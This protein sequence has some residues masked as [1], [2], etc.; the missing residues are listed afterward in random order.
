MK[1]NKVKNYMPNN[2]LKKM[3]GLSNWL[4]LCSDWDSFLR[5]LDSCGSHCLHGA[6]SHLMKCGCQRGPRTMRKLSSCVNRGKYQANKSR[7]LHK[8]KWCV[9]RPMNRNIILKRKN[10]PFSSLIFSF[11]FIFILIFLCQICLICFQLV[12]ILSLS[13]TPIL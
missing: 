10:V 3:S 2:L 11:R 4:C 8:C 1:Y 6:Y 13:L 7:T 12:S 9:T 5:L